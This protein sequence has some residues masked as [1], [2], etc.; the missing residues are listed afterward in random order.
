M[1]FVLGVFR[2]AAPVDPE[3]LAMPTEQGVGLHN[4]QSLL[5]EIGKSGQDDQAKPISV[6]QPRAV[7][8]AVEN[9]ELLAQDGIFNQQVRP[10]AG[11]VGQRARA[12]SPV[13]GFDQ[14]LMNL[15]MESRRNRKK[16]CK[17]GFI[18]SPFA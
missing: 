7:H 6:G 10:T 14:R 1:R 2:F 5:P 13:A 11:Q 16:N 8:L 15:L 3:K 4:V 12:S 9:D 18:I 17:F